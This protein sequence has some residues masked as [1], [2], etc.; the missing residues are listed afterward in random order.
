MVLDGSDNGNGQPKTIP[1]PLIN[2]GYDVDPTGSSVDLE[3][4]TTSGGGGSTS[5][6]GTL[7]ESADIDS[8]VSGG[9]YVGVA[10]VSACTD[11]ERRLRETRLQP[12]ATLATVV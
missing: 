4:A 7:S 10:S 6:T 8:G 12:D 5:D 3:I 11:P 2:K 1:Q 9:L